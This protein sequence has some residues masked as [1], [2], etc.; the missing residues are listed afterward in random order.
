[1]NWFEGKGNTVTNDM[2]LGYKRGKSAVL[3]HLVPLAERKEDV[4][5]VL[6]QGGHELRHMSSIIRDIL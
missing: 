1:M 2:E 3:D 5:A 6:L 4:P